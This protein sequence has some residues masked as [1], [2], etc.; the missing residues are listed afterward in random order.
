MK[1]NTPP[2]AQTSARTA[3]A[4]FAALA[5][6]PLGRAHAQ[7]LV[8][9]P[10][11]PIRFFEAKRPPA[12]AIEVTA[13]GHGLLL[14]STRLASAQAGEPSAGTAQIESATRG[15]ASTAQDGEAQGEAG[16]RVGR[17]LS[18]SLVPFGL[19]SGLFLLA[20]GQHHA[21]QGRGAIEGVGATLVATL[22]LKRVVKSKRPRGGGG[23]FPSGHAS[24]SFALATAVG[25]NHRN[26]RLPLFALATAIAASRVDVRAHR[27]RDVVAGAALGYGI[28]K[29]FMR[30]NR[31]DSSERFASSRL[32]AFAPPGLSLSAGGV[33]FGGRF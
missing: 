21:G 1:R 28:T 14:H 10:P 11:T 33:S 13:E 22:A 31:P 20:D 25:E 19:A 17:A 2:T 24:L 32:N 15:T 12:L 29:Y 18:D 6:C 7:A 9:A 30:R 23:S 5:L 3:P 4:I 16:S 8:A 26:A 27:V